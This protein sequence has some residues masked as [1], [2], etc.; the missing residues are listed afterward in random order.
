MSQGNKGGGDFVIEVIASAIGGVVGIAV[1]FLVWLMTTTGTLT[2]SFVR[3]RA[4]H[5]VPSLT[6]ERAR[7]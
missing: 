3:S 7:Q 5:R 6:R 4:A 2:Q 1:T